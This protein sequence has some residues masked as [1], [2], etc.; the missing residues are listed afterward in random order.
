M[1]RQDGVVSRGFK[2]AP[3]SALTSQ[4]IL[5]PGHHYRDAGGH[6]DRAD[7]AFDAPMTS[8]LYPDLQNWNSESCSQTFR[9]NVLS[10]DW[11][12]DFRGR[13]TASRTHQSGSRAGLT[14]VSHCNGA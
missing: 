10:N 4:R 7:R 5:W 1:R 11:E 12:N 6:D 9:V 13:W 3:K 14:N 8:I 2:T